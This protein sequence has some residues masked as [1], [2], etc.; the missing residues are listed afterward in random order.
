VPRAGYEAFGCAG[1]AAKIKPVSPEA[2]GAR[3][4]KGELNAIV[5]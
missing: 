4:A 3:Y 5:K 1:M 2:M